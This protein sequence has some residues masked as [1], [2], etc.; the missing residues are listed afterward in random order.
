MSLQSAAWATC[1]HA[2]CRHWVS[3]VSPN[4]FTG[5]TIPPGSPP[6]STS[7]SMAS[8]LERQFCRLQSTPIISPAAT[9]HQTVLNSPPHCKQ[10]P[11]RRLWPTTLTAHGLNFQDFRIG[12]RDDAHCQLASSNAPSAYRQSAQVSEFI[13]WAIATYMIGPLNPQ[14]ASGVITSSLTAIPRRHLVSGTLL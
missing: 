7:R 13:S 6:I 9:I 10:M 1:M 3:C 4:I 11:G 14:E 5:L 12:L 2:C 8:I